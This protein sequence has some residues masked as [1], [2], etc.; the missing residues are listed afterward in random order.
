VSLGEDRLLALIDGEG[1][2]AGDAVADALDVSVEVALANLDAL[3]K[4]GR[5]VRLHAF[6]PPEIDYYALTNYGVS[7]LPS[8]F[9]SRA[10]EGEG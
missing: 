4:L 10:L 8:N 5:V 7:C 3:I 2:I 1:C 6:R 9:D